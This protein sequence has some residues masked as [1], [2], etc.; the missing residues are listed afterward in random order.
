MVVSFIVR[1]RKVI[2]GTCAWVGRLR[3]AR[4]SYTY[5]LLQD[6]WATANTGLFGAAQV[7]VLDFDSEQGAAQLAEYLKGKHESIDY[8]VSCIGG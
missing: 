3:H 8:A 6:A 4:Q 1:V 2:C 5:P 7:P